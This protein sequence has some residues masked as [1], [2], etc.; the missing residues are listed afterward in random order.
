MKGLIGRELETGERQQRARGQST[1]DESGGKES[2]TAADVRMRG[3][4]STPCTCKLIKR[5]PN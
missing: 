3:G 2:D 1:D 4:W 5:R